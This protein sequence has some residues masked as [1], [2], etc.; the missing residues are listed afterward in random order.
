MTFSLGPRLLDHE[1]AP[2]RDQLEGK[3][4]PQAED[5]QGGDHEE[6][7]GTQANGHANDEATEDTSL[8]PNY[9]VRQAAEAQEYGYR[10][11]KSGWDRLSPRTQ[12]FLDLLYGFLNAPLIG[13]VI[14]AT[15]GLAPPLHRAFFDEP[16]QGGIFKA[17]LTSCIQNVGEI[18]AALQV[19]THT[20]THTHH[21]LK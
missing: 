11:G 14:G 10:K 3:S 16:Q 2:D 21:R 13:A 5:S 20:Y 4:Q 15:I 9:V 8:L 6:S 19:G 1:E 17:W 7:Q 12:S 18:F